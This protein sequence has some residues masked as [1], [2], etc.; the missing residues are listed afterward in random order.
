MKILKSSAISSFGGLN[1]VLEEILNKDIDKILEANLPKLSVQCKY[2]WKDI[3]FSYWSIFFCGGDCAED[4]SGNLGHVFKGNPYIGA[5][6]PDRLLDRLKELS[7]PST[8]FKKNRSEVEN[9]FSLNPLLN[10]LNLKILRKLTGTKKDKN[11]T[12]LDYDNTF[13]YTKKLDSKR[14]YTKGQGYCPGVG[15]IGQDIV[16]VENRNGNCAPHTLQDET[17]DRMFEQLGAQNINVDIFRADSASYQFSTIVSVNKHVKK[18]YIKAKMSTTIS[19]AI[20]A[21]K[22]WEKVEIDGKVLY[23]GDILYTPFKQVA[24]K[25]KRKEHIKEYRLVITKE[26]REDGQLNLFTGEACNYSPIVTND[27]E[28][29]NDEIVIFYNQRGKQEREFDVLKNDFG[30]NK[31]PFSKLEQNTVF[32]IIAG[33]CRNIYNYIISKFSKTY[34][35]LSKKFRIKKFIFRFICVPAKWIKTGRVNKLRIYGNIDFKT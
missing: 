10:E 26:E 18:F 15:I 34:K 8:I 20:S 35:H 31:M 17:I 33:I 2:S 11:E 9:E 13:I 1:F 12:V 30:W 25:T 6:S 29:T 24:Q 27:F 28:K 22:E 16:Y 5:P 7:I 32:L 23:R 14:T 3:F 4:I 21:I 19:S